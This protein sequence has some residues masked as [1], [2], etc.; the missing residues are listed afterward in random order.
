VPDAD[1]IGAF[2]SEAAKQQILPMTVFG[3]AMTNPDNARRTI[4]TYITDPELRA[5]LLSRID[6]AVRV[7]ASMPVG[8]PLSPPIG[9]SPAERFPPR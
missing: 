8:V 5:Q 1:L 2:S 9:P 4:E 7:R 3:A 6:A